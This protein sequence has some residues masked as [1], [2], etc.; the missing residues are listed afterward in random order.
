MLEKSANAIGGVILKAIEGMGYAGALLVESL[1]YM[2]LGR[3]RGQPVKAASIAYQMM[4]VGVRA[5]PIVTV[6]SFAV[7]VSLAIQSIYALKN[8]GAE[9]QVILAIAI[10]V[11]REFG[12][13]ITGILVAG[14]SASALA[15][16][17]GSMVVSQEVDALR[18]IG[19]SPVRYLVVPPL[20]ALVI[21]VPSLTIISDFAA[22]FGGAIYSLPNLD[23][24]MWAYLMASVDSLQTSDVTQ[25][26]WKAMTFGAIIAL[27]GVSSGFSVKGGA[28]G[29]GRATTQAVVLAISCIVITNMV[30]TFFLN[31]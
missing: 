5:I 2:V 1:Y 21:M 20:V 4:E 22:I 23:V 25:G 19:V 3:R 24:G 15:A 6:L 14:R 16:R 12:P 11:T 29:V 26:L 9:S 28:E 7:G 18:V 17:I 31:R 8:F 30:F 27:V 10:G 13:L